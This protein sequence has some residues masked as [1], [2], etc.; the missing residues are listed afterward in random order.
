MLRSEYD[1]LC[2]EN[3]MLKNENSIIKNEHNMSRNENENLKLENKRF[4][5]EYI[6]MIEDIENTR[7]KEQEQRDEIEQLIKKIR[8]LEEIVGRHSDSAT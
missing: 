1:V 2:S 5:A 3:N 7:R 4:H 8:S 6:R